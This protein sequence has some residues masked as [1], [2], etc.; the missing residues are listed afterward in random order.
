MY[1]FIENHI[2]EID[3]EA[4][5]SRK[6]LERIPME[7]SEW[8]PHE[9]SM[10]MGYLALLVAEIPKWITVMIK[11][12]EIDFATYTHYHP[13]TTEELVA[14]LNENIK[15]AKEALYN[16]TEDDLKKPFQLKELVKFYSVL[17]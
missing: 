13:K 7:L 2:K 17:L 10:A 1:P 15:G 12:G 11:E 9:K 16:A 8:K 5:A 6:C 4:T 14:H 3:A